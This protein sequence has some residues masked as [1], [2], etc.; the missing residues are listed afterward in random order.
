MSQAKELKAH[1]VI[2]EKDFLQRSIEVGKGGSGDKS[3]LSSLKESIRSLQKECNKKLSDFITEQKKNGT[4]EVVDD[5][6]NDDE[7]D[8]DEEPDNK[9]L[10]SN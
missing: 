5:D 8:S 9:K 1:I 2:Q 6:I 10:K 7:D 4:A 3:Y